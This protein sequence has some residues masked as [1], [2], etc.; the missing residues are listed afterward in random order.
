MRSF[1]GANN[2]MVYEPC[3]DDLTA[4]YP[5]M[6]WGILLCDDVKRP[7]EAVSVLPCHDH[8]VGRRADIATG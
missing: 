3:Y 8:P 6:A 5:C 2:G 4:A 1:W 7:A